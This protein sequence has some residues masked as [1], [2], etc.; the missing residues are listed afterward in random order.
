MADSL[1]HFVTS[2]LT[3]AVA[4]CSVLPWDSRL[5]FPSKWAY[6]PYFADKIAKLFCR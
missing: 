1:K 3:W 6:N 2:S 5:N 4:R